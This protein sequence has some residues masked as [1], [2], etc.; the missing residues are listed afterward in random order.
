VDLKAEV[1][2]DANKVGEGQV[3]GVS[4]GSSGFNNAKLSSIPLTLFAP[5][6]VMPGN[7]LR[8]TLSVRRTCFDAGH[9][10]GTPRLWF[11]DKQANSR[12][13]TTIGDTTSEAFLRDG[14]TL[15][16]TPGPG[17]KRTID[18]P[19]DI[20]ASCPGRPFKAFGTWRITLP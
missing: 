17:P 13:G 1:F 4:G 3:N 6:S 12:F 2:L 9:N 5:L 10:S 15:A 7:A 8:L 18:V 11:N 19:V 14:F 16:T 20:K